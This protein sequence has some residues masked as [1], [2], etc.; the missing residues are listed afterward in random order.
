MLNLIMFCFENVQATFVEIY[1]YR[2][3]PKENKAQHGSK[4]A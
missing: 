3:A 1:T 2:S 4:L